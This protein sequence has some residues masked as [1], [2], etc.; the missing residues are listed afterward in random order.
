MGKDSYR[1]GGTRGGAD[2][3]KWED[4][5]EDQ[6]HRENY[7][8]HSVMASQGRWQRGKDLNWY[9]RGGVTKADDEQLREEKRQAREQEEDMM[10][11]RLG[12][13]PIN[14][15][16]AAPSVRLDDREKAS[17]LKRGGSGAGGDMSTEAAYGAEKTEA[18]EERVGGLGSFQAARHGDARGPIQSSMAPQD[19]MEGTANAGGGAAASTCALGSDWARAGTSASRGPQPQG[20]GANGS[21]SGVGAGVGDDDGEGAR[22]KK[23]KH[24]KSDR[25]EKKKHK[26]KHKHKSEKREHERDERPEKRRRH[27]SSS[28]D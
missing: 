9:A 11:K 1:T 23:R 7:L 13:P 16:K 19:R 24:H 6:K 10:R 17:L 27:D 25:H 3:F 5:K 18:L 28:D 21:P 8:G 4:V 20:S 12:L 2:Q 22:E 26:H 15:E 14:R